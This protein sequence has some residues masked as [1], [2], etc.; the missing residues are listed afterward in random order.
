MSSV[1]AFLASPLPRQLQESI[2]VIQSELQASIAGARWTRP[3][4]LHL[5]LHFFGEIE[6]ETLEKL[7]VSVLSVKDCQRPFQVEVKGLGAFPDPYRPRVIW[8]G[9]EQRDQIE[10]LHRATEQCLRHAGFTP[11]SRPYSPHLTIGRLLGGKLDL[12]ELFSS[13]QHKTIEPLTVDRL[14]LYESRLRPEGAQHI[15]LLTVN[16]DDENT[17]IH[18]AT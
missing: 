6:Q 15:P 4:N 3:E 11:G 7:K 8:L 14:I 17:D 18:D 16:F 2:R 1:S 12:T 5:T 13:M 9:L 10:Q